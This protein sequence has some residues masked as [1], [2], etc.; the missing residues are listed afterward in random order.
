ICAKDSAQ[1][2]CVAFEATA[3]KSV[4]GS[5][6]FVFDEVRKACL[7]SI[8]PE[9]RS[10]RVLSDCVDETMEKRGDTQAVKTRA[11]PGEPVPPSRLE[12][13]AKRKAEEE[14]LAKR[15]AEEEAAAR[16]AAEEE[17]RRKAEADAK[18]RE[19]A[20]ARARADA[21]AR[22]RAEAE[23]KTRAEAEAKTRADAEAKARQ[24]AEAR[25]RAEAEA[26]ARQDA[27][28]RAR[29]EAEA[30]ARA[31]A[32]A[33][34]RAEADGRA[35]AE[36]DARARDEAEAKARAEA[37]ARAKAEAEARAKAEAEAKARQEAEAK[38]RAEAEARR[39]ACQAPV[40]AA[41]KSGAIRFRVESAALLPDS[42]QVLDRV[43]EAFKKC[44]NVNI[45]IEGHTDG[46]GDDEINVPLSENRA[47]TVRDYLI[48]AGVAADRIKTQGF[49][50]SKPVGPNDTS[51]GRAQNRRIEFVVTAP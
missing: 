28:A 51:E 3:R 35:K 19:E 8:K 11:T 32:D 47:S 36:A 39:V 44:A 22:A 25:A 9:D 16:R 42:R 50:S 37:E 40:T 6:P 33:R 31:A 46:S 5:W 7:A 29:A 12:A 27:E 13:E 34:A 1:G 20:E 49:G 38:S 2:Q 21:E 10:W 4:A 48:K 17:A 24:D 15:R 45:L 26:K 18:A 43:A 23:A 14:A 30:K 41:A